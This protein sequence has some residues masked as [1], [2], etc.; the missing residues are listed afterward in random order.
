M[1]N[2]KCPKEALLGKEQ[3][4]GIYPRSK[5]SFGDES[6]QCS[7]EAPAH[8]SDLHWDLNEP[9]AHGWQ[10]LTVGYLQGGELGNDSAKW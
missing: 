9:A 3:S 8:I 6:P 4:C 10:H 2:V 7:L 5:G 1:Q